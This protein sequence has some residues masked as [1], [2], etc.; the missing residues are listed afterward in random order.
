MDFKLPP[1]AYN[2]ECSRGCGLIGATTY[3]TI[4]QLAL[5]HYLT[6]HPDAD[7]IRVPQ[8]YNFYPAPLR[9][10]VCGIPVEK[11]YWSH[12]AEPK[13]AG[14][15]PL[16]VDHDGQWLICDPCHD[17]IAARN[18]VQLIRRHW[19]VTQE[20]SPMGEDRRLRARMAD[21]MSRRI[22][23]IYESF[24]AG[25]RHDVGSGESGNL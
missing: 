4:G 25:T 7:V 12:T 1:E 13:I 10:D 19:K 14:V 21:I 20:T 15:T 17:L 3:E 8:D 16:D 23:Q 18:K 2:V 22:D 9:C 6:L 24:D 5:D 11:P